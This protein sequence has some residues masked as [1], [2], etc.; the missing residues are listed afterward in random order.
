MSST[1][2]VGHFVAWDG[3]CLL[4]GSAAD[5]AM[6]LALAQDL[7]LVLHPFAAVSMRHAAG[8]P[9]G[10]GLEL[11]GGVSAAVKAEVAAGGTGR[12]RATPLGE[13]RD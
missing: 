3:G 13:R 9:E 7:G 6:V 12:R 4:I 2:G 5:R 11:R 10:E 8:L 1:A